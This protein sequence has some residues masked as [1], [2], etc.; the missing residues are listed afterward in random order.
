MYKRQ[1]QRLENKP[2]SWFPSAKELATTAHGIGADGVGLQANRH[3][4]TK[5]F[6]RQL[7]AAGISEFHV[8]T[9]DDPEDANFFIH[10]GAFAVA[11]NTPG[12]LRDHIQ[13]P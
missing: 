10:E 13:V 7:R 2:N 11:T 12:R 3:A 6:L 1:F 4:V 9:V 5:Q 8:W